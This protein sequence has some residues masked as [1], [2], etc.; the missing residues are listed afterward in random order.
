MKITWMEGGHIL[1]SQAHR[2]PLDGGLQLLVLQQLQ[3]TQSGRES[4][5]EGKVVPR[6]RDVALKI[7]EFTS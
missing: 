4:L 7:G 3:L 1:P 6:P 2:I 5:C